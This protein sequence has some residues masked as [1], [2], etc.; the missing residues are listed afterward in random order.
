M[1]PPCGR[2]QWILQRLLLAF[3]QLLRVFIFTQ[4]YAAVPSTHRFH[5]VIL[6]QRSDIPQNRS[7]TYLEFIFQFFYGCLFMVSK[8]IQQLNSPIPDRHFLFTGD[9]HVI[10]IHGSSFPPD[11]GAKES[12][13]VPGQVAPQREKQMEEP[14]SNKNEHNG[15]WDF[16]R[17]F[18]VK[19]NYGSARN[20]RM[21]VPLPYCNSGIGYSVLMG[22]S[23]YRYCMGH[24]HYVYITATSAA[25]FT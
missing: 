18:Q 23:R 14:I 11:A 24:G 3:R 15:A 20:F 19:P 8:V 17:R 21:R 10:L 4:V 6:R 22:N 12:P 25:L 5:G 7:S 2:W 16:Q 9:G 1:Y 13:C